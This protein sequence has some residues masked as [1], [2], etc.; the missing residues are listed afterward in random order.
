MKISHKNQN[1]I[2]IIL[3]LNACFLSI[4]ATVLDA[5]TDSRMTEETKIYSS[6]LLANSKIEKTLDL[7]TIRE[8]QEKNAAIA[9]EKIKF[10]SLEIDEYLVESIYDDN[11]IEVTAYVPK[12]RSPDTPI[13]VFFHGGAFQLFTRKSYQA[14]VGYLA[15]AT[16]TIWVSVEYR[17]NPI[18]G[19]F[20]YF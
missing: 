20:F 9:N 2:L 14:T 1:S 17:L 6:V 8:N 12:L 7:K 4:H 16:N 18:F 5:C 19:E 11:K 13:T 10:Y 3:L 15:E